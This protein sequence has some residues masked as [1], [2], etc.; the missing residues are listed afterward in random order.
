[1]RTEDE[2]EE[3]YMDVG[4]FYNATIFTSALK[5]TKLVFMSTEKKINYTSLFASSHFLHSTNLGRNVLSTYHSLPGG[6]MPLCAICWRKQR[7]LH[8]FFN[9]SFW[10]TTVGMTSSL[11]VLNWY[12][13][14]RGT[15]TYEASDKGCWHTRE[16]ES[17][18]GEIVNKNHIFAPGPGPPYTNASN[19]PPVLTS[20]YMWSRRQP[21]QFYFSVI[22]TTDA[23]SDVNYKAI[24]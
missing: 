6:V 5:D 21:V 13:N 24:F 19:L 14:V 20:C 15:F 9:I 23:P 3:N 22:K 10:N 7:F 11:P 17:C 16:D 1:M 12:L 2:N 8:S 4:H 18:L